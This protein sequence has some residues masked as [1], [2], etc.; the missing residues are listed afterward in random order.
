MKLQSIVQEPLAL[1]QG[2]LV[3][4]KIQSLGKS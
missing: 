1:I 3:V 2:A 4:I